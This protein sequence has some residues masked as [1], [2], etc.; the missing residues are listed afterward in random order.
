MYQVTVYWNRRS[1]WFD[2]K[3]EADAF[4]SFWNIEDANI[5][6]F[7]LYIPEARGAN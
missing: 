7:F 2:S 3:T 4:L 5:G 1:W 6:Y